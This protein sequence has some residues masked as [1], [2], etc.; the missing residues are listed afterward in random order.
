M[1]RRSRH[2]CP[3]RRQR[4]STKMETASRDCSPYRLAC[5]EIVILSEGPR[6]TSCKAGDRQTRTRSATPIRRVYAVGVEEIVWQCRSG[7]GRRPAASSTLLG[8]PNP[9]GDVRWQ[10]S[11]GMAGDL[12]DIGL[13]RRTRLPADP[14][15]G[16]RTISSGATSLHPAIQY[17]FLEGATLLRYG[18]KG[19]SRRA[20]STQCPA[21]S[22][23]DC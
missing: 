16:H 6:G 17:K 8:Y 2:W 10:F 15:S 1:G 19:D 11:H 22:P 9:A 13:G 18:A 3:H 12:L 4:A 14:T 20:A 7:Y 5:E 23:T 21:T